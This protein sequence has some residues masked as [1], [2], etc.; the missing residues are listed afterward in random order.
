M[1]E[2]FIRWLEKKKYCENLASRF[3]LLEEETDCP[4]GTKGTPKSQK[5]RGEKESPPPKKAKPNTEANQTERKRRGPLCRRRSSKPAR[6]G[7]SVRLFAGFLMAK[8]EDLSRKSAPLRDLGRAGR[9]SEG[10]APTHPKNIWSDPHQKKK[11][12]ENH[13]TNR[14]LAVGFAP[15]R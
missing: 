7:P 13:F 6:R 15:G 8:A 10:R 2:I 9:C 14:T 5:Q 12:V 11:T 4:G 1:L 3:L